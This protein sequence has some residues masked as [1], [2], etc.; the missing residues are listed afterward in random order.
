MLILVGLPVALTVLALFNFTVIGGLDA[1][2]PIVVA[3]VVVGLTIGGLLV[4]NRIRERVLATAKR[5]LEQSHAALQQTVTRMQRVQGAALRAL[6]S[7]HDFRNLLTPI[8]LV[9]ELVEPRNNTEKQAI[10]GVLSSAER[11]LELSN[12][13]LAHLSDK[14][15]EPTLHKALPELAGYAKRTHRLRTEVQTNAIQ[16]RRP[17]LA[18]ALAEA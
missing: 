9:G 10:Q 1:T 8:L 4:R 3:P 14:G 18:R 12:N 16:L 11:A 5:Q 6:G 2:V 15:G 17:A 7:V 13:I